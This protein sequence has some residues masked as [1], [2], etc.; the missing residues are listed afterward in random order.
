M[1]TRRAGDERGAVC[2]HRQM[3]FGKLLRGLSAAFVVLAFGFGAPMPLWANPADTVLVNGRIATLDGTS[4]ISEAL[5]IKAGRI[6]A[7][8]SAEE[9]RK[10]AGPATKIIDL[11]GRTVIPGLIDSHIHAIRAGFRYAT[12]VHWDGATGIG[13]A[14]ERLRSAAVHAAPGAW[15][16]VA[17]GWTPRQFTESRRPTEAE[18]TAVAGEHPVYIQLFYGSMLINAIGRER[19]GI[20]SEEDLP[21]AI[22]DHGNGWI[23]GP[24]AVITSTYSRL[25]KPDMEQ[26]VDGTRRFLRE[27]TRFG[28]T[29]VIDP[30]GHNLDAEDYAALFRLWR[31]RSLP[32]RVVYSI[33]AP[34]PGKE[35]EDFVAATRFLPMGTGDDWLRF[36]GI[37]ECVTW[38]MYNNETPDEA[39]KAEFYRVALWAAKQGM[40][41]TVH[42]NN[43]GSVHHLLDV[44]EQVNREIPL[45]KLRWSIA[46]LHDASDSSLQRMKALG[47]GWLMQDGLYFSA[48]SYIA[49]RGPDQMRRTPPIV[50]A[51]RLAL[52]VGGGTDANRVMISNPFVSLRWML[53]GR[54]VDGIATRGAEEIP[55]REQALRLYTQGSAWF[56]HDEDRRGRLMPGMLA[57]LAVLSE[58]YFSVSVSRVAQI[59]SLLT[60]V[61]GKVVYAAGPFSDLESVRGR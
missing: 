45:A 53:D 44:L 31:E 1:A 13:E 28:L 49:E 4:S 35:L 33:S 59:Q 38:G 40:T 42:W 7:T 57:D 25:P 50:S 2:H 58:D 12:E 23:T 11:D 21:G 32:L 14:M 43:D 18:V 19:L 20:T 29:G 39:D 8:G 48:P 55:S 17:G 24:S 54:T 34:R 26:A 37:G 56:A 60:M 16:I 52:P 61:G 30:G 46:H 3:I 27:L 10:L 15:L 9:M 47:V 41:L 5:A 36:N 22:F 6:T 51:L